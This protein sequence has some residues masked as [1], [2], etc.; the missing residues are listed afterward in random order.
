MTPLTLRKNRAPTH[1]RKEVNRAGHSRRF[2]D[3]MQDEQFA[4]CTRAVFKDCASKAKKIAFA[5]GVSDS[6]ARHWRTEGRGN[7]VYEATHFVY[8]LARMG[9]GA[10]VVVAHLMATIHQA[11]LPMTDDQIVSRF[12]ELMREESQAEGSENEA[13]ATVGHTGDLADLERK[14]LREAGLQHE[15]AA[16]IRELRRRGINPYGWK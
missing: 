12:F 7:F 13:Q 4:E 6:R 8:G 16:T 3:P 9:Q 1:A 5:A 10:G 2:F 15:L 11:M 14:T